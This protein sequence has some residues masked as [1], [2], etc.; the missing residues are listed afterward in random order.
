MSLPP[1]LTLHIY[2]CICMS[3]FMYIGYISYLKEVVHIPRYAS[4]VAVVVA[5]ATIRES[6]AS[7]LVDVQKA[8]LKKKREVGKR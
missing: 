7:G 3:V 8:C 5:R 6:H 4:L 2:V 1:H